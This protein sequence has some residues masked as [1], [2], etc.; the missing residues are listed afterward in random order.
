MRIR[1]LA[2]AAV[3]ALAAVPA[4][5]SAA[6]IA[7]TLSTPLTTPGNPAGGNADGTG[8]WFNILTGYN[9]VRGFLFPTP[10]FADGQFF[11]LKD[12]SFTDPE[13]EVFVQ[14]FFSRGN[15][16][17]YASAGNLNPARFGDG[18]VIGPGVGFQSPGAGF[19]DLGPTFGNWVGGGHGY[20]GFTIRDPSGT[21]ASD[22]FY[23][24]ADIDIDPDYNITLNG[25][26]YN[27]VRNAPIT[28]PEPTALALIPAVGLLAGRR[29]R[30]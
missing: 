27:N 3:A 1:T 5:S 24:F 9:E 18:A 14:G 19:S 21:S 23:G 29:R 12:V 30:A 25:F 11:L 17:I 15:G 28:V 4:V 10:L 7:T 20:L 8:V 22:I 16:V 6:I 26:A 13:A 2:L